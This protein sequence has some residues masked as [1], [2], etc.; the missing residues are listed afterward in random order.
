M[1]RLHRERLKE[2]ASEGVYV[3]SKRQHRR[4]E[5]RVLPSPVFLGTLCLT[6]NAVLDD[7]VEQLACSCLLAVHHRRGGKL[8]HAREHS[9]DGQVQR[10]LVREG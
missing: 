4:E 5:M 8:D 9:V 1:D 10:R 2:R 6:T 7:R 3:G